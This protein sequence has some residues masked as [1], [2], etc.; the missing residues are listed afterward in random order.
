MPSRATIRRQVSDNA[1]RIGLAWQEATESL[2]VLVQGGVRRPELELARDRAYL[3]F[4]KAG[5]AIRRLGGRDA[6]LDARDTLTG[7][8]PAQ[9]LALD[10]LWA[11]LDS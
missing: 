5:V 8:Y 1:Q 9:D 7:L 2:A 6:L 10:R 3:R 4:V 11:G